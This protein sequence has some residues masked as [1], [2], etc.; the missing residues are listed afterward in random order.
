MAEEKVQQQVALRGAVSCKHQTRILGARQQRLAA[1]F[2][3]VD[4][5]IRDEGIA[6]AQPASRC[7]VAQHAIHQRIQL[8]HE[9]VVVEAGP[10]PFQQGEFRIV[11]ATAL[12]VAEYPAHLINGSAAR[13][14]KAFHGELGGCLQVK[15][16]TRGATGVADGAEAGDVHVAGCAPGHGRRLHLQ[17]VAFGE[18]RPDPRKPPCPQAQCLEAGAR[19]PVAVGVRLPVA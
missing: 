16:P 5:G 15:L 6:I 9:P 19:A 18:E 8:V 13:G 12:P 11:Q 10:I 17:H 3:R 14:Q 1:C 2:E 7:R 4:I